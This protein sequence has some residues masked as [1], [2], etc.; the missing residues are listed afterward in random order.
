MKIAATNA[1]AV[2]TIMGI[3]GRL[4]TLKPYVPW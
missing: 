1:P 3:K 2:V 4:A